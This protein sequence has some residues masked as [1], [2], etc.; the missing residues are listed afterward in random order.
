M[1]LCQS[2]KPNPISPACKTILYYYWTCFLLLCFIPGVSS[3]PYDRSV[4]TCFFKVFLLFHRKR[5]SIC[6]IALHSVTNLEMFAVSGFKFLNF[7][8]WYPAFSWSGSTAV[9]ASVGRQ[10][11]TSGSCILSRCSIGYWVVLGH[12]TQWWK[13]QGVGFLFRKEDWVIYGR[14]KQI[15]TYISGILE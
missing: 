6:M 5:S 7:L 15:E 3:S 14:I 13:K 11:G 8:G 4:S 2:S 10:G 12:E 9:S 1:C